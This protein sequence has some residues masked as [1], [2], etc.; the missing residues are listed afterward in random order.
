MTPLSYRTIW[1]TIQYIDSDHPDSSYTS[2]GFLIEP[3]DV[4]AT[5]LGLIE[6]KIF[7]LSEDSLHFESFTKV[8]GFNFIIGNRDWSIVASRNVKLFLDTTKQV[9]VVIPYDFDFANIVGATYRREI[10]PKS[11]NHPFDRV[12]EGEYFATQVETILQNLS[13]SK[14][15]LLNTIQTAPNPIDHSRRKKITRYFDSG[16]SFVSKLNVKEMKYGLI[17]PYK[18]SL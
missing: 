5:R 2:A 16:F 1:L 3:D 11:M 12:L 7:S 17:C 6:K 14:S 18:G 15:L 4:L 13:Q 9:Y 8:A 10:L